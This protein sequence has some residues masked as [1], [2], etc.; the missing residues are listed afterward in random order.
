VHEDPATT[1][2]PRI[3]DT[4]DAHVGR[5]PSDAAHAPSFSDTH[6]PNAWVCPFL[7]S[8]G[9]DDR[10]GPP[11]EVP[12]PANRCAA[13]RDAVPQ[14]LRQQELVCLTS[15]HVNCPRHQRG[16][17][18]SVEPLVRVR[19]AH[20]VTPAIAGSVAL[21]VVAFLLSVGFV[22]ANGGLTLGAGI[23]AAPASPSGNVLGESESSA[24]TATSATTPTPTPD[25][26]PTP[27][28]DVTP[29]PTPVVTPTP[30]PSPT[31]TATPASTYPAGATASRMKLLTPC[32]DAPDCYIYR[33]RSGDN[34]YSIAKYFGVAYKTVKAWNTWTDSGLK[35]GR[36]LRIPPP[37]R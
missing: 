8:L 15:G 37:T 2:P 17:H 13:L 35:V 36:E 31:P 3:T 7:R 6:S 5:D 30:T 33:I 23:G 34:L 21:L 4:D 25:V 24:P 29:T 32:P 14:S 12:D 10:L 18:P 28:P 22:V 26:T 27:T 16:S 9:D 11:V 19:A 20:V 1:P